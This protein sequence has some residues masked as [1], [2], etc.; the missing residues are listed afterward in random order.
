M[1]VLIFFVLT[2]K[3]NGA[4]VKHI[5]SLRLKIPMKLISIQIR[6]P[7]TNATKLPILILGVFWA[8]S[9]MFLVPVSS[10]LF[11]EEFRDRPLLYF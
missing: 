9:S 1:P 4:A 6:A 5:I 2:N 11:L 10:V 3:I 8:E 7:K